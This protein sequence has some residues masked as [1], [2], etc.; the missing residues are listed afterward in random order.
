MGG[1]GLDSG[2]ERSDFLGLEEEEGGAVTGPAGG[3]VGAAEGGAL[4]ADLEG[5]GAFFAATGGGGVDVVWAGRAGGA[6][7]AG[8]RTGA[9]TVEGFGGTEGEGEGTA[10]SVALPGTARVLK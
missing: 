10:L 9:G 1:V 4:G 6:A 8:A 5:G 3:A 7:R 2:T